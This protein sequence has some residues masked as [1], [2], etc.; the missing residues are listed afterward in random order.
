MVFNLKNNK[1]IALAPLME[2][3]V[4]PVDVNEPVNR[5]S[6]DWKAAV[7][8]ALSMYPDYNDVDHLMRDKNFTESQIL[9]MG[10]STNPEKMQNATKTVQ[11][12]ENTVLQLQS[13][14]HK[15]NIMKKINVFNLKNEKTSQTF[16]PVGVNGMQEDFNRNPDYPEIMGD[17]QEQIDDF[18]GS[19]KF[20]SHEDVKKW[21]LSI[22][23]SEDPINAAWAEI[24]S[25]TPSYPDEVKQ[26]IENFFDSLETKSPEQQLIDAKSVFDA[27]YGKDTGSVTLNAPKVKVNEVLELIKKMAKEYVKATIVKPYNLKKEAQHKTVNNAILW[28]PGQTRIDPFLHQPVSDWHIV[29]RNKGF[30]LVVDDVWNI[31]WE[32]IWRGNIMDKYS[33]AYRDKDGNWVGGYIQKRFEVDK[34]IPE[35]NNYQLKPGQKRRPTPPQYGSTESRLQAARENGEIEGA[36][37]TSKPFNWKEA[38][39]NF[40]K[41]S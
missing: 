37:D 8:N 14:S 25:E 31:D 29:E 38:I 22:S 41:K 15:D 16:S 12:T 7:K 39:S 6:L 2:V 17:K 26:G 40:K 24:Q 32:S 11:D 13:S 28:G 9:D 19:R 4:K 35:T 5:N 18:N 30:G 20:Q 10:L 1:K 36:I 21:L 23:Q 27:I 33:R 3:G 34:N